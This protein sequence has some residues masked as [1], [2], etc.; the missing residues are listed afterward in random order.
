MSEKSFQKALFYLYSSIDKQSTN[1]D[2]C[3]TQFAL[4]D[5]EMALLGELAETQRQ[6][7]LVF[8]HQLHHKGH[9]SIR[10]G[11]GLSSKLVASDLEALIHDYALSE[12]AA[13]GLRDPSQAIRL[14][15]QF[16]C[17]RLETGVTFSKQFEFICLESVVSAVSLPR[18]PLKQNQRLV[19]CFTN[20]LMV[21]SLGDVSLMRC[22]YD[23]LPALLNPSL[24]EQCQQLSVP[25]WLLLFQGQQSEVRIMAISPSLARA[26]SSLQDNVPLNDI[27]HAV[28]GHAQ[29]EALV[30]A[31]KGLLSDGV[32]FISKT[33]CTEHPLT[34]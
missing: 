13:E 17:S 8:N 14:F 22:T 6:G 31:I 29:R 20:D 24:F 26:L 7:L 28:E 4:S 15:A 30:A 11:L 9:R 1:S 25:R 3:F 10:E 2:L 23:I 32:P 18:K 34:T 19:E 12:T 33:V 16:L 27:V 5:D 21:S